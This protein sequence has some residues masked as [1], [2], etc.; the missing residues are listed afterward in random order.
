MHKIRH[1][2]TASAVGILEKVG[3][4]VQYPREQINKI[5]LAQNGAGVSTG[6]AGLQLFPQTPFFAIITHCLGQL[7]APYPKSGYEDIRC[8]KKK[9][10]LLLRDSLPQN[11]VACLHESG[12]ILN[13]FTL[14]W[15]L[16]YILL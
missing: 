11:V 10:C 1:S 12:L 13:H 8:E 14:A 7:P 16:L 15:E 6:A 2:H 9:H 5:T 4:K 3:S